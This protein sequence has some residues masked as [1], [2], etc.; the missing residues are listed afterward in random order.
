MSVLGMFGRG[1]SLLRLL[2]NFLLATLA[3]RIFSGS[4]V[5]SFIGVIVFPQLVQV[6]MAQEFGLLLPI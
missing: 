4:L 6:R 2:I 5:L 1:L 3:L